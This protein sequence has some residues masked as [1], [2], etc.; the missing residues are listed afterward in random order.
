M[1]SLA[2]SLIFICTCFLLRIEPQGRCCGA[3]CDHAV[4]RRAV[5]P[6][7]GAVGGIN[8]RLHLA[9]FADILDVDVGFQA[10][11][12]E[13]RSSRVQHVS[14]PTPV[15]SVPGPHIHLLVDA[16]HLDRHPAP[17]RPVGTLG[18]NLQFFGPTD[19]LQL[20][21]RPAG[22]HDANPVSG[23]ALG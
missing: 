22:S 11:D 8:T 9:V 18:G 6:V 2:V 12:A 14:E 21:P 4:D 20:F 23:W 3:V 1:S 15:A 7:L 10:W 19:S 5:V 16:N 13:P 17:Q